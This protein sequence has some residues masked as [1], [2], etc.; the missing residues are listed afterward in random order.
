MGAVAHA[1]PWKT[2]L[3]EQISKNNDREILQ[4]QKWEDLKD[5]YLSSPRQSS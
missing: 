4:C 1:G 5:L 2:E 3:R